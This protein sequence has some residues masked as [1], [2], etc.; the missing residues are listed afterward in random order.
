MSLRKLIWNVKVFLFRT[1][2]RRR[3]L[4]TED[5]KELE[6]N[7]LFSISE[8]IRP[9]RI[10]SIGVES[11]TAFYPHL[12]KDTTLETIDKDPYMTRWGSSDGHKVADANQIAK[13]WQPNT[14]DVILFNGV[15]GWGIDTEEHL[16]AVLQAIRTVLKPEGF[17]LFGWNQTP[18]ADPL[19]LESQLGKL[20]GGFRIGKLNGKEFLQFK[21]WERHRYRFFRVSKNNLV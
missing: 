15:Y 8:E 9:K 13:I 4:F 11:F 12:F 10:L 2:Y 16:R 19:D 3:V 5:R 17:L 1:L 18:E 14:F 21:E 6:Y 20:F 7:L